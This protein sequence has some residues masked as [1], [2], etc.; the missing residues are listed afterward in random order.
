M[1]LVRD[2]DEPRRDVGAGGVLHW[3]PKLHDGLRLRTAT[4]AA[5]IEKARPSLIVVDVSVEVALF[6]RL[7]GIPVVIAAMRGS[8]CDR[9]HRAAY[10]MA[11]ALLAPWPRKHVPDWWPRRWVEKTWHVG[12][13]SQFDA[14]PVP[15][16]STYGKRR[17]L[18]LAG[19]GGTDIDR[20]AV[21]SARAATPGWNWSVAGVGSWLDR[22]Q[23]W[24]ALCESDVVLA[25]AGQTAVAE[26]A[27]ARRPAIIFAQQRPHDEQVD[28]ARTL[29]RAGIAIGLDQWPPPGALPDLLATAQTLDP[30]RWCEWSSG[31]GA[32][33]AA[34]HLDRMSDR[35]DR[36]LRPCEQR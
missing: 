20:Q 17:L 22:D 28:T 15:G 16:R 33:R 34:G 27:A 18:L 31:N 11:D 35:L 21:V 19:H 30:A 23:V 2:D 25:H 24:S 12:A 1:T 3:A 5:W 32:A 4:I 14:A 6:C 13:F 8:R 26:V 29:G 9:P 36:R 10:D 7:M